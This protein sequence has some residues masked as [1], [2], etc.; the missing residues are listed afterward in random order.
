MITCEKNLKKVF[1]MI[2]YDGNGFIDSLEL[3]EL[4][5][6]IGAKKKPLRQVRVSEETK[7]IFTLADKNND[8]KIDF[9]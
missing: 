3:K 9:I 8:G 7:N 5:Q 6:K 2:D 1:D 4:L